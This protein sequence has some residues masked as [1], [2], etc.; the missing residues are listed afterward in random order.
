MPERFPRSKYIR[1]LNLMANDFD[2]WAAFCY[3]YA[4]KTP[5]EWLQARFVSRAIVL[6]DVRRHLI[7]AQAAIATL[8]R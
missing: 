2:S 7:D 1:Q 8:P 4:E 3:D 5:V 6:R